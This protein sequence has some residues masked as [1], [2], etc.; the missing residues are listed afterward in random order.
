MTLVPAPR[1]GVSAVIVTWQPDVTALAAMLA[2]LSTQVDAAIVV[3]NASVPW[4][5]PP[6]LL[7]VRWIRLDR[8]QGLAAAQNRG[9]QVAMD[10]GARHAL[11]LDQDS[12]PAAGMVQAMLGAGEHARRGGQRVAA[13]GPLVMDPQ[14]HIKGFVRFRSG[15]YEAHRPRSTDRWVEC[16]MLIASGSLVLLEAL[17]D[18][19]PMAEALFIDKVD[20]E[21]SLR[22]A[23]RGYVLV[24]AP[25]A[26][27]HHRVGER[28][29]RV[30][31]LGWR[32]LRLHQ[33][34]RYYYI[35]RNGL[36]LRRLPHA[37]A[38]WRRADLRQLLSHFVY[39]GVLAPGR[40]VALRM[41]LRGLFDGLRNVTGPLR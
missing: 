17:R 32:E 2:A 9:L 18:I 10:S 23:A 19:G 33:P 7:P 41:M 37:H 34:F 40:L 16:D 14:G 39:F 5:T 13:V 38:A 12:V 1:N 26:V 30:W 8:N 11:L 21:W 4:A 27:L 35:V 28:P 3:D 20:T 36:L 6:A 24:G 15:R 31:F 22:A 25:G 29:L